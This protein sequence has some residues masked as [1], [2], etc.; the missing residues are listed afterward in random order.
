MVNNALKKMDVN[1]KIVERIVLIFTLDLKRIVINFVM[2]D[3]LS[4]S[5]QDCFLIR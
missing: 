4:G 1:K 2:F 3:P 5:D